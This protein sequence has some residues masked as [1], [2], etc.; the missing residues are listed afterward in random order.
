MQKMQN[1]WH[2]IISYSPLS[3]NSIT[4]PSPP[5]RAST[6]INIDLKKDLEVVKIELFDQVGKKVSDVFQ[7]KLPNGNSVFMLERNS[8]TAQGMYF[9]I[10]KSKGEVITKRVIFN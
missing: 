2:L 9:V 8:K 3:C 5:H 7:G 6:L 10:L 1:E 4:P